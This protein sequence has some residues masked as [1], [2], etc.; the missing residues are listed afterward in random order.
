MISVKR[1]VIATVV[2]LVLG[3]L[4]WLLAAR[5]VAQGVPGCGAA[6][7]IL[8]LAVVGFVIGISGLRWCWWVHGLLLGAIALLPLSLAG[9]WAGLKWWP[10]FVFLLVAGLIG[11]FL[12]ELVTSLVFRARAS[13]GL[14]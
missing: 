5:A 2:G 3:V 6:A 1:V 10:G 12:T 8:G 13:R 9:V 11:G 14:S 4:L 7:M